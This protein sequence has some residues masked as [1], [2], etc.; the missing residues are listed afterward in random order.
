MVIPG[1]VFVALLFLLAW[2]N[3]KTSNS[4]IAKGPILPI[5]FSYVDPTGKSADA[6]Y[7][8]VFDDNSGALVIVRIL[9]LHEDNNQVYG[10]IAANNNPQLK[11]KVIFFDS[12]GSF[13]FTTQK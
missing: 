12:T 8:S 2:P 3:L 6:G 13:L 7:V 1:L 9:E 4:P 10:Y 5:P 11:Q